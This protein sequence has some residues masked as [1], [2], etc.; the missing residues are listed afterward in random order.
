MFTLQNIYTLH[1]CAADLHRFS[2]FYEEL[3]CAS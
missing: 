2:R 1:P 3:K